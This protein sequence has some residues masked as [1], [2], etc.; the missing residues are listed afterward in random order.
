MAYAVIA[1]YRCKPED[2]ESVRAALIKVRAH[3]LEEPANLAYIVHVD[4]DDTTAFTLYE[5][6]ADQA[7]FEAHTKTDHFAEHILGTVRPRLTDRVVSF[8]DVL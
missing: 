1:R 5:Q 6:Y 3:T 8:L 7:G 2:A 4:P